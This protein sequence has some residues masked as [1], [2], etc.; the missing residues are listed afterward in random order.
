MQIDFHHTVTYVVARLA[1]F[2]KQEAEIVAHS[3]QY[4]DDA[5]NSGYITFRNG[6]IYSRISSAHKM[7]DYRNFEELANHKVWIPFHFLPGNEGKKAGDNLN[8]EFIKKIICRPDSYV[9]KDIV[10]ACILD[11]KKPYSLHRLGIT[12]HAYADTWAHQGFAGVNDEINIV[13]GLNDG[14]N[15]NDEGLAGYV[16]DYFGKVADYVTGKVIGDVLPLGHGAALSYPDLP[17]I[18]KLTYTNGQ[19]E[20]ISRNN[21][22]EFQDAVQAMYRAMVSYRK[23]DPKFTTKD[24]IDDKDF[25]MISNNLKNFNDSNPEKRHLM[26]MNSIKRGDFSFGKEKISYTDKGSN[27]WKDQALD[28]KKAIENGYERYIFKNDFFKSNW[29]LFHDALMAYSFELLHDILPEYHIQ[30]A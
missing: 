4:V 22:Q 13:D 28:T 6:A 30:A 2:T 15:D 20:K 27:S 1:G 24:S 25:D 5:V 29:K 23:D 10:K 18:T 3:S 14:L 16:K 26:W 11:K 21:H 17:Y 9:A 12:M 19:K 8:G 7:L